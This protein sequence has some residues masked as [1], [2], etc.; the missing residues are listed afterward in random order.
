MSRKCLRMVELFNRNANVHHRE[1]IFENSPIKPK[2][3]TSHE[4][5]II[6]NSV[7]CNVYADESLSDLWIK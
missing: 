3:R 6:R 7:V 4:E 5:I 2:G 1:G